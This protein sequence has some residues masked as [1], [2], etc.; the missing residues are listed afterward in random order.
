MHTHTTQHTHTHNTHTLAAALP[1][2]NLG[3][4]AVGLARGNGQQRHSLIGQRA[5]RYAVPPC[6]HTQQPAM[7]TRLPL[8]IYL[9]AR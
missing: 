7:F 8:C 2:P 5:V 1:G 4:K 9:H 3:S 6:T